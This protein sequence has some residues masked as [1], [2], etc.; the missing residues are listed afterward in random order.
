MAYLSFADTVDRFLGQERN[1]IIAIYTVADR[2]FVVSEAE[3]ILD[4][5]A[6]T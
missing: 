1:L 2:D 5:H 4:P 3:F 6:S